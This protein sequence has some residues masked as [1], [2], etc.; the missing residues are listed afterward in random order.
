[1]SEHHEHT[2]LMDFQPFRFGGAKSKGW[3]IVFLLATAALN[4][5]ALFGVFFVAGRA[6]RMGLGL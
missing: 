5:G 2:F 1:M 6:L 4:T 3:Q